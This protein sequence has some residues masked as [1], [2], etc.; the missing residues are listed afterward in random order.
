VNALDNETQRLISSLADWAYWDDTYAFVQNGNPDYIDTNVS[1]STL[2][3]LQLSFMI[4][5]NKSDEVVFAKGYDL[6]NQTEAQPPADLISQESHLRRQIEP[7]EITRAR[8]GN[9]TRTAAL[10]SRSY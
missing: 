7:S 5:V 4:F 6:A 9:P 8:S 2:P 10:S 3:N 1:S